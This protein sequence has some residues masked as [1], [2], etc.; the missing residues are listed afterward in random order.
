MNSG[1]GRDV[2]RG[3][4][5]L[6]YFDNGSRGEGGAPRLIRALV[7]EMGGTLNPTGV[8]GLM[9]RERDVTI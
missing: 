8:Q 2:R 9:M 6:D 4:Y 3:A 1:G 5:F 7:K